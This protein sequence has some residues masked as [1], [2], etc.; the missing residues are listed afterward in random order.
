VLIRDVRVFAATGPQAEEHR[1]VLIAGGKMVRAHRPPPL[2]NDTQAGKRGRGK[3]IKKF[4]FSRVAF[5]T[6]VPK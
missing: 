6:P 1:D 3:K 4:I 2:L 5:W